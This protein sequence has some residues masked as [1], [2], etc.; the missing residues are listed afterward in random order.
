[1]LA[2]RDQICL[3][4]SHVPSAWHFQGSSQIGIRPDREVKVI[5]SGMKSSVS[6]DFLSD[7]PTA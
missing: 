2:K 6:G 3:N 1:M 5:Q 4:S 7:L